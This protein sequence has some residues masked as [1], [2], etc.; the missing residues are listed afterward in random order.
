MNEKQTTP[1]V[2]DRKEAAQYL[3]ISK[4]TLDKL[5]IPFIQV[6]R[7]V[8]YRKADIDQFL[9]RQKTARVTA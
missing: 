8:L 1:E 3:S 5:E 9:E 2:L 4:G 7:R 6:R